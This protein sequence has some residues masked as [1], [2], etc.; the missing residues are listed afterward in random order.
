MY[1]CCTQAS[2]AAVR[3]G[4]SWRTKG[5]RPMFH[6][7]ATRTAQM[8][9]GQILDSPSTFADVGEL[10]GKAAVGVNLRWFCGQIDTREQ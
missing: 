3:A 4:I 2:R 5:S 9:Q 1:V 6:A 8:L 10:V 7:S